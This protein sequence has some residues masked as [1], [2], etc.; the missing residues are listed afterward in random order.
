MRRQPADDPLELAQQR[1]A[2]LVALADLEDRAVGEP[3]R[4]D[5][6]HGV[7]DRRRVTS[8]DSRDRRRS[9]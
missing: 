9:S 4:R 2:D 3:R 1:Q 5:F 8:A 7:A 6:E